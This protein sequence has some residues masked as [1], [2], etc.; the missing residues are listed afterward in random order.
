MVLNAKKRKGSK[1]LSS[2]DETNKRTYKKMWSAVEKVKKK[3][4]VNSLLLTFNQNKTSGGEN[5]S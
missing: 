1:Q 2:C 5:Y 3:A 4:R